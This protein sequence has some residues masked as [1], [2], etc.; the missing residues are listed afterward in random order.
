M[1]PLESNFFG[2]QDLLRS[3]KPSRAA[4]KAVW[5]TA[6]I[7]MQ[8]RDESRVRDAAIRG[9]HFETWPEDARDQV[10]DTLVNDEDRDRG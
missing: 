4:L 9:C 5:P 7:C 2:C 6:V 3:L 1:R 8:R 10:L